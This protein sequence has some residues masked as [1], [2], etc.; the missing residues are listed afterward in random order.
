MSLLELKEGDLVVH[1]SHGIGR[2]RGLVRMDV[3]GVEREFLRIDYHEPDKLY[4]PS[5]QLDRVQK[6]IGSDESAP[7]LHR[8]GGGEWFRTK[9]RVKARVKEMAKE[10]VQLYAARKATRGHSFD[11]DT[12]WQH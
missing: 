7:S 12:V 5:D 11:E 1:V 8:L 6:Y 2:Y 9:S 4:V 3:G 10:L